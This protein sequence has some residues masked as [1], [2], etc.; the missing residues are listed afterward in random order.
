VSLTVTG[1]TA[2]DEVSVLLHPSTVGG[3]ELEGPQ[4]VVGLLELG[5]NS[6]NLMN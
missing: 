6:E 5:A 4:E 1:I 3:V 2:S